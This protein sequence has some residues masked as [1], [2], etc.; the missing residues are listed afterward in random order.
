[1]RRRCW[2][3]GPA[4]W[5]VKPVLCDLTKVADPEPRRFRRR[6]SIHPAFGVTLHRIVVAMIGRMIRACGAD[7]VA[8]LDY[9]S[10]NCVF[11]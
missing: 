7:D 3:T 9:R 5:Q 10:E 6:G 1:L 2:T 4:S 8:G 11:R